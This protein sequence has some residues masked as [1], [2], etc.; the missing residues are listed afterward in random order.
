MMRECWNC[1]GKYYNRESFNEHLKTC[2][3]RELMPPSK[4][5][6]IN[7]PK[8]ITESQSFFVEGGR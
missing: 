8:G 4:P 5:Q 7:K 3:P 1:G 6:I 2:K